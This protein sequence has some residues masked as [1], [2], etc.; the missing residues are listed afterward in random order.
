MLDTGNKIKDWLKDYLESSNLN[1]FVIGV[2]G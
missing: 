1:H 2:S